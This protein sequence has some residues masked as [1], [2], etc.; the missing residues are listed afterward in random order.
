MKRKPV[1]VH[2]ILTDALRSLA[3]AVA[4]VFLGHFLIWLVAQ[5]VI[6][7]DAL[8]DTPTHFEDQADAP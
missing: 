8:G 4:I 2:P 1:G 3:V 5:G 6:M 7:P